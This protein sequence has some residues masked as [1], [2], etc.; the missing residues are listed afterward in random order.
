M[1]KIDFSKPTYMNLDFKWYLHKDLTDYAR[2]VDNHLPSLGNVGVF[3][4]IGKGEENIVMI[5]NKQNVLLTSF[6]NEKFAT[7]T[8]KTKLVALKENKHFSK[9]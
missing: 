6:W 5:D 3:V 9:L 4:V 2:N 8:F 7:D 1:G